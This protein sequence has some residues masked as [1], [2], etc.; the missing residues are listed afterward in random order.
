MDV[1]QD[2]HVISGDDDG[3]ESEEG[4]PNIEVRQSCS[5]C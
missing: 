2:D 3:P 4:V 5:Y 1:D